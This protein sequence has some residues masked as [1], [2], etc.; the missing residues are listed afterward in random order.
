[1]STNG[2]D[3]PVL[4]VFRMY[5]MM[6]GRRVEIKQDNLAYNYL[7]VRDESVRGENPDINAIAAKEKN[8]STVMVWNYHDNNNLDVADSKV[9]IVMNGLHDGKVLLTHYRID[10]RFS[11]SYTVW[12][13]M[14]S[15]QNPTPDQIVELENAGQLQLYSSPTWLNAKDGKT[16]V[17]ME[18]P[19]QGVSLL[20]FSW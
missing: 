2:V 5:G 8:T 19:R 9:K 7:N 10:Q 12:K 13:K 11:N 6:Q 18:L 4:N 14:G 16:I 3:K 17:E 15:P 20:K 1:M